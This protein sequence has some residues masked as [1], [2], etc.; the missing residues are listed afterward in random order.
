MASRPNKGLGFS[1]DKILIYILYSIIFLAFL[2]HIKVFIGFAILV[3]LLAAPC[4]WLR[5][6]KKNKKYS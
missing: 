4:Y 5:W 3:A 1:T 6:Y 2:Q